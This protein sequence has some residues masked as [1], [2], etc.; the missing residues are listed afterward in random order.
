MP[1]IHLE[2][3]TKLFLSLLGL[4]C[5]GL[6]IGRIV[7]SR[8]TP[9]KLRVVR[10][11]FGCGCTIPEPH[12]NLPMTLRDLYPLHASLSLTKEAVASCMA[13]FFIWSTGTIFAYILKNIEH[14]A[15]DKIQRICERFV[16]TVEFSK[17]QTKLFKTR[18]KSSQQPTNPSPLI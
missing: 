4:L 2:G 8:N 10:G 16:W 7:C 17:F 14:L 5:I 12:I 18:D 6:C 15:K 9:E 3:K 13:I 1:H 11:Q